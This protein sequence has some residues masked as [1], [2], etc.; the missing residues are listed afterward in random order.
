MSRTVDDLQ[1]ILQRIDSKG[2]PAYKEIH[3]HYDFK[4]F[5]LSLDHIQG[6]PFC[7][8]LAA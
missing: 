6:D 4:D 2:Y 3:G 1:R 5:K 7:R 8:T